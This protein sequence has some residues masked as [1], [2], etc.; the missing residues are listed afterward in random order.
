MWDVLI[1]DYFETSYKLDSNMQGIDRLREKYENKATFIE[2]FADLFPNF[3]EFIEYALK[4]GVKMT[5]AANILG[6]N[7]NSLFCE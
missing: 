5:Q 7:E 3:T 4:I 6:S 1:K 2:L